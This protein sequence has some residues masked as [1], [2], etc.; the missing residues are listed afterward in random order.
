MPHFQHGFH[1]FEIEFPAIDCYGYEIA[2]NVQNPLAFYR[3]VNWAIASSE[4]ILTYIDAVFLKEKASNFFRD[5]RCANRGPTI[6]G[7]IHCLN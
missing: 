2:K 5:Y 4:F 6:K 7:H 3:T 1:I